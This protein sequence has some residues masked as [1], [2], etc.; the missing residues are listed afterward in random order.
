MLMS[1]PKGFMP[2]TPGA[3]LCRLVITVRTNMSVPAPPRMPD[4]TSTRARV[5]SMVAR[6]YVSLK[7]SAVGVG[8]D[9]VG[10]DVGV[11]VGEREGR[12]VEGRGVG[13]GDGSGVGLK[14]GSGVGL[15]E[16]RADGVGWGQWLECT[17][18]RLSVEVGA[19]RTC[20]TDD[21]Q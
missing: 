10:G 18:N 6:R 7:T 20:R 4:D 16:R 21:V 8:A 1:I 3:G 14:V 9:V 12:R 13:S 19:M 2:T 17:G 11:A 15:I 5:R